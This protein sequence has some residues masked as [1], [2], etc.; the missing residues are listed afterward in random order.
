MTKTNMRKFFDRWGVVCALATSMVVTSVLR[1][2]DATAL[3]WT[4]TFVEVCELIGKVFMNGLKMLVVPLIASS[5]ICGM[6][7]FGSGTECKRLGLKTFLFY[8]LN[9]AAAVFIGLGL[10]NTFRPGLT[11]AELAGKI[12]G[13]AN[14]LPEH[15]V[16]IS[17]G[18]VGK[19]SD[20]FLRIIPTNVISAAADNTQILG[21]ITFS[22]LFGF[23]IGRLPNALRDL[24]LRFWEG[25]Q[26]IIRDITRI[27]IAFSPLG[28]FGLVT[29]IL[30]NAGLDVL[31]PLLYFVLTVLTGFAIHTFGFLWL[32]LRFVGKIR[33]WAHY[34]AMFPVTLMAFSTSSSAAALPLALDKIETVSKVSPKT[35]RFTLPLGNTIN[36]A[37]TALYECVVV[38][39]LAQLYQVTQGIEFGFWN[40]LTVVLMALLTSVGVAGIPASALVAITM[41][42]GS[43]GLPIESVGIIWVAER[44]LDMFR[45]VVNVFGD[46]CGAVIVARSEGEAT[47]YEGVK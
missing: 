11:D 6:A 31:R 43:V 3:P 35:A 17:A 38:L 30:L 25:L 28:V 12:L 18:G 27:V 1:C 4:K 22:L 40:Q 16:N 32:L 21:L 44:L 10:V 2:A 41:I 9:C 8:A 19:L 13:Q 5:L 7:G 36:M 26:H 24:Q 29:P 15:F 20:F 23:F 37:G 33:P 42:V 14:V 47:A 39:F 46:T 45:T 34:K